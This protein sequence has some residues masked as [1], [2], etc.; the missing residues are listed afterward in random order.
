M[1][2]A[3]FSGIYP[4]QYAF[5]DRGGGLDRAAMRRQVEAALA[6]ARCACSTGAAGTSCRTT[7]APGAPA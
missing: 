6:G 1:S 7:C 4:M 3:E 5:F 2:S